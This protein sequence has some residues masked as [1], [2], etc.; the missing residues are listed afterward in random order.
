M[1]FGFSLYDAGP[2]WVLGIY[3]DE[4]DVEVVQLRPLLK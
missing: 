2:D 3:K 1:P 4:L